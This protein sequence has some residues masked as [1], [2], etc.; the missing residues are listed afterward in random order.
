MNSFVT[1]FDRLLNWMWDY[2]PRVLWPVTVLPVLLVASC[3]VVVIYLCAPPKV[4]R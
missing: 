3:V 2:V 4:T 1:G